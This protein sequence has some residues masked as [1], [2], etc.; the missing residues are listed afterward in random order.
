MA[1]P[2]KP[3]PPRIAALAK[4]QRFGWIGIDGEFQNQILSF[5]PNRIRQ[6][7][8]FADYPGLKHDLPIPMLSR[9]LRWV[10]R[11]HSDRVPPDTVRRSRPRVLR[12]ECL[13][14]SSC[15]RIL[16]RA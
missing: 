3:D 14:E 16:R 5:A 12:R 13:P 4:S 6:F 7:F 15:A 11:V 9:A 2:V 10:D 1:S 8:C